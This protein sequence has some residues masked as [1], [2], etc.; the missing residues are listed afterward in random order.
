MTLTRLNKAPF[1]WFEPATAEEHAVA[2][3]NFG[4]LRVD[5]LGRVWRH[6]KRTRSGWLDVEPKRIDPGDRYLSVRFQHHGKVVNVKAH[7]LVWAVAYGPIPN[8]LQINHKDSDKY[9]NRLANLE[10]VTAAGNIQHSYAN[11]RPA[12]WSKTRDAQSADECSALRPGFWRASRPL[13]DEQQKEEMV[14]LRESGA[15]L[16][17]IAVAYGISTSHAFRLTRQIGGSPGE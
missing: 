10:L 7:R 6:A 17:E 14:Q 3:V 2:L 16:R 8:G 12:P 5:D 9:N 4:V 13:I 15:L 11:G 1:P